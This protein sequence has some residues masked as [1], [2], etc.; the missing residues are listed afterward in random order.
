MEI[1]KKLPCWIFDLQKLEENLRQIHDTQTQL[2]MIPLAII[3]FPAEVVILDMAGEMTVVKRK[4]LSLNSFLTHQVKITTAGKTSFS[5]IVSTL[6]S[7]LASGKGHVE[8]TVG[9]LFAGYEHNH[10][11]TGLQEKLTEYIRKNHLIEQHMN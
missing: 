8:S 2:Q 11:T 7:L 3:Y 1:I 6:R 4:N 5:P 9:K 10:K